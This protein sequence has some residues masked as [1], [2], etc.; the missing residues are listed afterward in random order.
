[1]ADMEKTISTKVEENY[2]QRDFEKI[3]NEKKS[4]I[5]FSAWPWCRSILAD[6]SR[7]CLFGFGHIK[8]ATH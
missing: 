6:L 8:F 7:A 2:F 1:M 5:H 4:K 3:V